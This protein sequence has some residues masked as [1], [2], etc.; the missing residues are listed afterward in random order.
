MGLLALLPF[1]LLLGLLVR[2]LLGLTGIGRLGSLD[3]I[4][5]LAVAQ[6]MIL[7]GF[8]QTVWLDFGVGVSAVVVLALPGLVRDQ[9][10]RRTTSLT[11][12]SNHSAVAVP[13]SI[14]SYP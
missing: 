11:A 14:G 1:V 10:Q 7:G 13:A 4:A 12:P 9:L 8:L 5:A 3:R 6:A 2:E